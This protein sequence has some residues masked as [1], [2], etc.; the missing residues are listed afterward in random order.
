LLEENGIQHIYMPDLTVFHSWD[1]RWVE[2]MVREMMK[3]GT[4]P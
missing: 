1:P 3:L 4:A 2:P